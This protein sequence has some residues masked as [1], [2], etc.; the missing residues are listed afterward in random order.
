MT[1]ADWLALALRTLAIG[2][3]VH[4][5]IR[6]TV[7]PAMRWAIRT[8]GVATREELD[9][10]R[11]VVRT[12]ALAFGACFALLPEVWPEWVPQVWR[13]GLGV[14]GGSVS[15]AAHHAVER[16]LP[17]AVARLLGPGLSSALPPVGG[18][19]D[20]AGDLEGPP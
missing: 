11:W 4:P 19:D 2:V 1:S 3:L 14:I 16:A 8:D 12:F 7:K 9:L 15:M 6:V 5:L 13:L 17:E 10:Y 20:D 18:F